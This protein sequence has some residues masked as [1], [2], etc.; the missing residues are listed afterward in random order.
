MN[1]I[2]SDG[3]DERRAENVLTMLLQISQKWQL[4]KQEPR[5]YVCVRR[6]RIISVTLP[7]VIDIVVHDMHYSFYLCTV[8]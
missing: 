3:E 6:D 4:A 5:H 8:L 7:A 2:I 1:N